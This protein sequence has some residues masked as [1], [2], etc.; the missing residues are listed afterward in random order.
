MI[1][2]IN[3]KFKAEI[4]GNSYPIGFS[5]F[6]FIEKKVLTNHFNYSFFC[7]AIIAHPSFGRACCFAGIKKRKV[8]MVLEPKQKR[9][10]ARLPLGSKIQFINEHTVACGNT[11]IAK[12]STVT[13]TKLV[14]HHRRHTFWG[15]KFIKWPFKLIPNQ[16]EII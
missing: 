13:L 12:G 6:Y 15:T 11:T 9:Q 3:R 16:F 8:V 7:L 2:T 14:D 1:G 10:L 5:S 4:D